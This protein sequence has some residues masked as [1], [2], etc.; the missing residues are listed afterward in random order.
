MPR[1][2]L[3]FADAPLPS[4]VFLI[5]LVLADGDAHGYAIRKAI[6]ARTDGA[7][8]LDPGSLYR[9][10]AR[11]FEQD[12][13]AEASGADDARRRVYRLTRLGRRV[14]EAEADRMAT[15]ASYV[16]PRSRKRPGEA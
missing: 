3:S 10:I 5:L 1:G 2:P 7:I 16:R 6:E 4:P 13:I 14:L 15:L 8:S 12:L 9:L 11:L